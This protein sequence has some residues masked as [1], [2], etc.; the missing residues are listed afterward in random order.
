MNGFQQI[1]ED[2]HI[3]SCTARLVQWISLVKPI[4]EGLIFGT[5]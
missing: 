1:T 4:A 3:Q 5:A 2:E